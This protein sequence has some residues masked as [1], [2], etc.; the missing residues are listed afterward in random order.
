MAVD[1]NCERACIMLKATAFLMLKGALQ[2][3]RCLDKG[4]TLDYEHA[5]INKC[6]SS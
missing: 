2:R 1:G 5:V 4:Q 3:L 6:I